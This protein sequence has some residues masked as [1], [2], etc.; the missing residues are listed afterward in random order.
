[1][2]FLLSQVQWQRGMGLDYGR[3]HI[4]SRVYGLFTRRGRKNIEGK[5]ASMVLLNTDIY[6]SMFSMIS[7]FTDNRLKFS[8]A[9]LARHQIDFMMFFTLSAL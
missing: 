8:I 5:T 7:A 9:L 4:Q 6:M 1:M 2:I 3:S